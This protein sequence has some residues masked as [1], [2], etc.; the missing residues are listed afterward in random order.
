MSR[1]A[2]VDGLVT[3][4]LWVQTGPQH[5][6]AGKMVLPPQS[7]PDLALFR[8]RGNPRES[9][10]IQLLEQVLGIL[11]YEVGRIEASRKS[12]GLSGKR[13]PAWVMQTH[14]ASNARS[15]DLP[16]LNPG[17]PHKVRPSRIAPVGGQS[18]VEQR[19]ATVF[20]ASD[21]VLPVYGPGQFNSAHLRSL[22]QQVRQHGQ[23][24]LNPV[25]VFAAERVRAGGEKGR[26][27]LLPINPTEAAKL[28][29]IVQAGQPVALT[30]LRAVPTS[31][32]NQMIEAAQR[33]TGLPLRSPD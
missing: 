4:L 12:F 8:E 20:A 13:M 30:R 10:M 9:T 18:G 16:Q 15:S 31:D 21:S 25:Y 1:D 23:D 26:S 14:P 19:A 11:G 17:L 3:S 6:L 27:H 22:T 33:Y 7:Q 2:V 24:P 5:G 32:R 29:A 28:S